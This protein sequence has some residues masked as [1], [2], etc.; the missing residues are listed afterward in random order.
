MANHKRIKRSH[1]TRA[2]RH[3]K[4]G[5]VGELNLPQRA[6]TVTLGM[7]LLTTMT[8]SSPAST[9]KEQTVMVQADNRILKASRDQARK[10]LEDTTIDF[11]KVPASTPTPTPKPKKKKVKKVQERIIKRVVPRI[12]PKKVTEKPAV[13]KKTAVKVLG[14][15]LSSCQDSHAIESGLRLNAINLYR[16]VCNAFPEAGPFGGYRNESGSYHQLGRAVDC[17]VPSHSVGERVKDWVYAHR[18]ELNVMEIIWE[19]HIWTAQRSSEGFRPMSD[20][21]S[22]TANHMDHVHV[23][24][25]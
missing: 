16:A 11:P 2:G 21:G 19:Q 17:M 24:L 14:L 1:F 7:A 20:R 9:N 12:T 6:T 10:P 18:K 22:P 3:R 25:F 5:I 13:K 23:T 15:D 8:L 4:G